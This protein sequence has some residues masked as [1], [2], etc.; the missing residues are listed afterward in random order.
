[1]NISDIAITEFPSAS[2]AG[3]VNVMLGF[4]PD[5]AIF[6]SNHGGTNPDVYLWA[7]NSVMSGWAAALALIITGASGIITRQTSGPTVFAGGT[8]VSTAE[9]ANSDPK[10]VD[11]DGAPVAAAAVPFITQAGLA[12][13]A[14]LQTS[15]GRNLLIA[16]RRNR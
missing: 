15:A 8:V 7:D 14:A 11:A 2:T 5:F 3:V 4:R 13:P 12:I 16:L 9:T 1:M 10:H 6:I